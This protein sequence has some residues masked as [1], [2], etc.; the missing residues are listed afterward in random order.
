MAIGNY[1]VQQLVAVEIIEVGS[2]AYWATTFG[3]MLLGTVAVAAVVGLLIIASIW[4]FHKIKGDTAHEKM[5][6]M[7]KPLTL[8]TIT[9]EACQD[10]NDLA[11]TAEQSA[12]EYYGYESRSYSELGMDPTDLNQRSV[13]NWHHMW[14]KFETL[15]EIAQNRAHHVVVGRVLNIT[16]EPW[17]IPAPLPIKQ[18]NPTQQMRR[19]FN[20]E[21]LK[22]TNENMFTV[23][24]LK[25]GIQG[26]YKEMHFDELLLSVSDHS[27]HTTFVDDPAGFKQLI[28]SFLFRVSVPSYCC[29]LLRNSQHII[30]AIDPASYA[31]R[32]LN[33]PEPTRLKWVNVRRNVIGRDSRL[34]HTIHKHFRQLF[35]DSSLSS[36]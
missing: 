22:W 18:A 13:K 1:A 7:S 33:E 28:N 30:I 9:S 34:N 14:K 36:I 25:Q 8:A 3:A 15:F 19:E 27:N 16:V 2:A 12:E 21:L 29:K 17:P 31:V 24:H 23:Y 10:I 20:Q 11:L 4:L 5:Q 35:I 6:E 26:N 32:Y